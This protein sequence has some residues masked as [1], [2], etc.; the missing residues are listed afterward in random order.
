MGKGLDGTPG[1]LRDEALGPQRESL[2]RS[3]AKRGAE[4]EVDWKVR[5][6]SAPSLGAACW[7][8]AKGP[9]RW[10]LPGTPQEA[11][12]FGTAGLEGWP[13]PVLPGTPRLRV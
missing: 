6:T 1:F 10:G 12:P 11:G 13:C 9:Q 4:G 3:Q 2:V 8:R 5:L 7:L